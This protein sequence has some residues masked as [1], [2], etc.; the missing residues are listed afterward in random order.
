MRFRLSLIFVVL[1]LLLALPPVGAAATDPSTAT[2]EPGVANTVTPEALRLVTAG[3]V[4]KPPAPAADRRGRRA[5]AIAFRYLGV[6]YRW[7]GA[8]R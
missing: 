1:V 8:R 5:V 2:P 3:L 6:P 4:M 7:G